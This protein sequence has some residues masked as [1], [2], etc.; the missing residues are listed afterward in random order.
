MKN[1]LAGLI[2]FTLLGAG[3]LHAQDRD[4]QPEKGAKLIA[5]EGQ[6]VGA[7]F[8][9]AAAKKFTE[10]T[11]VPVTV[12]EVGGMVA[13]NKLS[14]D[15]P[16]GRGA[17]VFVMPHNSIG[18]GV[19]AGLLMENLVSTSR[20]K[21][22]FVPMVVQAVTY[23]GKVYGFPCAMETTALFYNKDLWKAPPKTFEEIVEF[24]KTWNNPK[25][26][27]YALVFQPDNL[28]IDYGFM[29]GAGGYVFGK[30]G[31]DATDLGLNNSATV[32]ALTAV[33]GL[34]PAMLQK[35]Q[36]ITGDV[37]SGLFSEGKASAIIGGPWNIYGLQKAGVNFGIVPLPTLAGITPRPFSGVQVY[38]TSTYS[39][40]PTAAQLFAKFLT[41]DEMLLERFRLT[42]QIPP[43]S[44]LL[45]NSEVT[46]SSFNQA[47]V[48]QLKNSDPMPAI[49]EINLVWAPFQTAMS[50]AW[51]GKIDVKTAMATASKTI[52][53]QIAIQNRK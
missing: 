41:S 10:A 27:K 46:K 28:Y 3:L 1:A 20:I 18:D 15:G 43:V 32:K 39:K 45:T 38:G 5:W 35:A 51:S 29:A 52:Q 50:D 49:P 12:E 17:D 2:V 31:T 44:V 19:A 53:D 33:V 6:G 36:D 11:G 37:V 24:G 16:A 7:D 4:V 14:T 47:F 30:N 23:N 25:K 40:Y 42:D 26:N 8:L 34:R 13:M 48:A 22:D 9:R 21:K